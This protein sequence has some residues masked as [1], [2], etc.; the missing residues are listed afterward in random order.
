V[1][2]AVQITAMLIANSK[3]LATSLCFKGARLCRKPES[4]QDRR[5][6]ML[7]AQQPGSRD[8]SR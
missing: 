2:I 7:G 4:F 8:R 6:M 3:Q 1:A 5:L